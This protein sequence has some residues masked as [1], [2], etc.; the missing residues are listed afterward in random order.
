MEISEDHSDENKQ[1]YLSRVCHSK[2]GSHYH[3]H[4]AETQ[5]QA[6]EGGSFVVDKREGFRCALTRGCWPEEARGR[7]TR[8][9]ESYVIG[10]RCTSGFLQLV[11]C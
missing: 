8:S 7:P 6:E 4:L 2:G 11:L 5:R 10:Y 9:E 3:L 1:G